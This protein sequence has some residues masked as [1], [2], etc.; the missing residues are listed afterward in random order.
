MAT[1]VMYNAYAS[2]AGVNLSDH[3]RTVTLDTGQ[4]MLDDTAMGDTTVSNAAGL[5]TWS[6][7]IE[8]LQDYAASNVDATLEGELGIANTS[9]TA[10]ILKPNGA[11]TATANPKY[12]GTAILESYNPIAG[13][14]GDQAMATATFQSKS[15]L[16]RATS[17]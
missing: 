8:F 17:D 4:N 3:V 6:V 13:T 2:I 9:G 7:T 12:T 11:T 5:A 1:L 16:T 15:A 10:L 14:V